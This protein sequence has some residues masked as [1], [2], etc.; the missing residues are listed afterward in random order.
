M[1]IIFYYV[2]VLVAAPPRTYIIIL[3]RTPAPATHSR[4]F[5]RLYYGD[6]VGRLYFRVQITNKLN[7]CAPIILK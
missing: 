5:S 4:G 1:P 3:K 6:D 7:N 2:A